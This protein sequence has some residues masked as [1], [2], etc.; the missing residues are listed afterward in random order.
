MRQKLG[1]GAFNPALVFFASFVSLRL[2][3]FAL[4]P[5]NLRHNRLFS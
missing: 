4:E 3:T 2:C 5:L 1:P